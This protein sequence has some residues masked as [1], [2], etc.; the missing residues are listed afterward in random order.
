MDPEESEPSIIPKE[1][2]EKLN[3]SETL[4]RYVE[5]GKTFQEL[6]GIEEESM[7]SFYQKARSLLE[8]GRHRDAGDVFIFLTTLNPFVSAYWLGLGMCEQFEEE[9]KQALIAYSMAS[10][11]DRTNPTPLYYAAACH[12][13]CG[14]I[15][16]A[17]TSLESAIEVADDHENY[18]EIKSRAQSAQ[19]I[20]SHKNR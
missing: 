5:E 15:S 20:L 10:I 9:Y 11:G 16:R 8:A 13:A 1:H 14:D 6:L 17:L 2:L 12:H 7:D 18:A 4:R 19:S 3:D